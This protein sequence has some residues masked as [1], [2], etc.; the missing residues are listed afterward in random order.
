MLILA[1]DP[2]TKLGWA[3]GRDGALLESGVEDLSVRRGESSGARFLRFRRFL[4]QPP[5]P[6]LIVYEQAHHRGG[7]ATEV[8]VGITTRIQEFAAAHRIECVGIHTGS[9]KKRCTGNGAAKK[10][11]MIVVA[12]GLWASLKDQWGA[13]KVIDD[14]EADALC[15]LWLGFQ[16]YQAGVPSEPSVPSE[17]GGLSRQGSARRTF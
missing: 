10:W 8:C 15:L 9:L 14:N 6:D 12:Q 5:R 13:V 1:V 2:G 17:P 4:D 11:E 16:D 3:L 7:A